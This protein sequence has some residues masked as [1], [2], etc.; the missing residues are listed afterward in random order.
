MK[1]QNILIGICAGISAYK[2]CELVRLLVKDG[3]SVKVMMTKSATE[4]VTPLTFQTLSLNLVYTQMFSLLNEENVQH[5][6]LAQW[7]DVC[8]IAPATA[9]TLSKIAYGFCD[10]LLTTVV[11][12]L[13]KNTPVIFAPAMNSEMWNNPIIQ[14]NIKKLE[15]LKKYQIIEPGKGA[16]ACGTYGDGRMAEPQDIFKLFKG[17]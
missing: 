1:K 13:P 3:Y 2:T 17:R 15:S 12:A 10:N 8:V 11:C 9:N 5:I 14:E 7:A 6:S 16:L 4:F